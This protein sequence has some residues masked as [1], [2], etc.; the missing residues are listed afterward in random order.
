MIDAFR[1]LKLIY[2]GLKA[3][4]G[5]MTEFTLRGMALL[6]DAIDK[7]RA[8]WQEWIGDAKTLGKILQFAPDAGLRSLGKYITTLE[9]GNVELGATGDQLRK[10]A[11]YWVDVTNKT[12]DQIVELANQE[13]YWSRAEK[14]IANLRNRATEYAKEIGKATEKTAALAKAAEVQ[15]APIA[16]RLKSALAQ[17]TSIINTELVQVEIAYDQNIIKLAEYYDKRVALAE[18]NLANEIGY[19]RQL[20]QVEKDPGKRLAINDQIRAAEAK[21]HDDMLKL[22]ADRKTAE[23]ALEAGRAAIGGAQREQELDL[24]RQAG[25]NLETIHAMEDDILAARQEQEIASMVEQ[26][27]TMAQIEEQYRLQQIERDQQAADQR[28]A[29]YELT[30]ESITQSLDFLSQAAGD[31][32]AASGQQAKE[33]FYLQKAIAIVQTGIKTYEAAQNAYTSASAIPIVGWILGP[34]AAAAAIAAGLARIAAIRNQSLAEGGPVKGYS[35]TSKSDNIP[36]ML[37][38][39]E[40]VHPVQTV[41]Y[42]GKS[43]MEAIRRRLIPREVLSGFSFP[44]IPTPAYS[45]QTGGAV[46][47]Q[48]AKG[49]AGRGPKPPTSAAGA[50]AGAEAATPINITN[51]I[52]PQM[53]DQY[54]ASKP[55]Q[56]NIMNVMSQNQFALKQILVGE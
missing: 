41:K 16:A 38:A 51:I 36:A 39:D 48:A 35:P 15:E 23:D 50:G 17:A 55:G 37:T 2:L 19:L 44:S 43:A 34:I 49:S 29:I 1:G 11:E 5:L 32:Y 6:A 25:A 33:F 18:E 52:D 42:Y 47:A 31:A 21:H 24:A 26:K 46:A 13:M 27:A 12:S 7:V 9:E 20:E 14:F 28:K 45:F 8:K 4:F 10:H 22:A 54:V 53:M 30:V 40:F 3:A 56:R